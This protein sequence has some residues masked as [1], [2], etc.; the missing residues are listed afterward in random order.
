MTEGIMELS[1]VNTYYGESKILKN[2]NLHFMKGSITAVIGRNGV[3]KSTLLKSIIGIVK[4]RT[5]TISFEGR[6]ISQERP[7]VRARLGIGYVPQGRE[8]F[9]HISVKGNLKLG[10]ESRRDG[11]K[12]I[13]ENL[14]DEYFPMVSKIGRRLGGNLSGGQQQQLAIARALVG[15]PKL[16]LL[17]EPTEGLQPSIISD[18]EKVLKNLKNKGN[19][20]IVLVEQYLE[21]VKELADYFYIFERGTIVLEGEVSKLNEDEAKRH[22]AF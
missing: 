15:E 16:L 2:I 18:I 19:I 3:G 20:S 5:G 21:F 17:D 1:G 9:P 10:L 6:D 13:P 11:I 4:S 12:K 14:V 7:E 22:L 8:I